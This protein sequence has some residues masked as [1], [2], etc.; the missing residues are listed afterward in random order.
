M[1]QAWV[2]AVD[3]GYGHQRAAYP[4]RDIANEGIIT[5]NTGA[6]VDPGER[7]RWVTLQHLYEGVS[8]VN[9]VPVIGPWL[10]RAYD[11]LQAIHLY[12]PFRDL[13]KP[14]LGSM[15]LGRLLRNGFASSVVDHTRK[16]DDLPLLTTFFAV[17]E[18]F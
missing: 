12:Y 15:R 10:W 14:S 11:R 13:S 7:K 4:F 1:D 8:R 16:R 6:M 9:Q 2:V 18:A 3:M 17:A 5:A